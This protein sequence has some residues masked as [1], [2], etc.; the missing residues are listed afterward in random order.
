MIGK[1]AQDGRWFRQLLT[2]LA[3]LVSL[4]VFCVLLG[5]AYFQ[6]VEDEQRYTDAFTRQLA[7]SLAELAQD[8]PELWEFEEE[9]IEAIVEA[10]VASYAV[11]QQDWSIIIANNEGA[12]SYQRS[13]RAGYLSLESQAVINLGYETIGTVQVVHQ[14]YGLVSRL[15]RALMFAILP[16]LA[17]F[18]ILFWIPLRALRRRERQLAD[19]LELAR[20]REEEALTSKERLTTAA[21]SMRD[22]LALFG[23]DSKLVLCNANFQKILRDW[24]L[25]PKIGTGIDDLISRLGPPP[26]QFASAQGL[27]ANS[28]EQ[29]TPR[30]RWVVWTLDTSR[31]GD[32][33]LLIRDVT[34]A[35]EARER[36]A[37]AH[38]LQALG[39][40]SAGIAH[41]FNNMLAVIQG[42][43]ELLDE[44]KPEQQEI[45]QPI[46]RA[47]SSGAE[48]T[49]RLLAFARQQPLT[50]KP[51][52]LA[53]LVHRWRDLLRASLGVDVQ[54]KLET[55]RD[56]WQA[57]I[58]P[59]LLENALLNLAVNA[60]DAMPDGGILTITSFNTHLG[61]EQ[62]KLSTLAGAALP[63]GDYIVLRVS[64]N[65]SGMEE[66]IRQRA[67]EPF[68]TT[69]SFG[70]GSG[71]GLSMVLGFAEQS[72]GALTLDSTPGGG[73]SVTLYLP[74]ATPD[75][76]LAPS[77][78]NHQQQQE[79]ALVR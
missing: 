59:S 55:A 31:F 32:H 52:D 16:S 39:Q 17:A 29:K 15:R 61:E 53:A 22:G 60:R 38:H 70:L 11:S 45:A 74:R 5:Q 63:R 14:L 40:L 65:G 75:N 30:G 33:L 6:T 26:E 68:F 48:L 28:A 57:R 72:G 37:Q 67:F 34:E 18:A 4:S 20:S 76:D 66:E 62:T 23:P 71:M 49:Q 51:T 50:A 2:L 35:R 10:Q 73:T 58:D 13:A 54:V 44:T 3:A 36:L 56:L 79:T 42:N 41:D 46:L 69:K 12:R 21:G 7:V 24:D 77:L 64:D 1:V 25:L 19:A 43:I 9:R 8:N 27:S 47:C 78:S